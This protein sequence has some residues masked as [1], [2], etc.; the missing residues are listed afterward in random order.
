MPR[1][2]PP[3]L[4]HPRIAQQSQPLF[5]KQDGEKNIPNGSKHRYVHLQTK[6]KYRTCTYLDTIAEIFS[7]KGIYTIVC[8]TST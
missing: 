1:L 6:H 2:I 7:F 3:L 8:D 4:K 5:R